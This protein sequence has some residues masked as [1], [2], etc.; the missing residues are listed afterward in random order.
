[1]QVYSGM[2]YEGP[3]MIKRIK[4]GLARKFNTQA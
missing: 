1:M 3:Y 4:E 2:I